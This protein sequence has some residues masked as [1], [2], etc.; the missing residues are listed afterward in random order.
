VGRRAQPHRDGRVSGPR[1]TV[2][3]GGL[4]GISA[5]LQCADAGARVTLVEVRPRLGGAVYSF[6]RDGLLVDNGQHVFMR[7]CSAYRALLE[8]IGATGSTTLQPRLE[9]PVIEPGGRVT[10]IRRGRLPAPLHLAATLARYRPLLPLKRAGAARAAL[11]LGRLDAADPALDLVTFGDWLA[12]HGQGPTEAAALWDLIALA[13]LNVRAAEA[14]LGVA[15]FAFQTALLGDNTA[16]DIGFHER[17]LSEVVGEPAERALRAAG[18]ALRLSWRAEAV[19]AVAGGGGFVVAGERGDPLAADAV[20]MALPPTRAAAVLPAGAIANPERLMAL[21]S[22]PI[23]NVHVIYERPVTDLAFVGGLGTPV[24]YVFD[25]TRAAG[26]EAGQYLAVSVSGADAEM[27]MTPEALRVRY[28]SALAELFPRALATRVE[29][30]LVTREHAATFRATP[31]SAALRPGPR[32]ALAGL[33]LAGAWTATGWPATMEGAVRSGQA[34]AR[35]ALS[36]VGS[37]E[38]VGVAA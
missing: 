10:T 5:A 12:R 2:V 34:A 11:A 25:R 9:V 23:V 31:G 26:V 8:R 24:Q 4:A 29:R 19:R 1:V 17:A 3:G 7:C 22:S 18:V 36:A 37:A 30:F 16:G 33:A 6:E 20:V 27:A 35:E 28:E 38:A 13:I 15:A 14:S 21:G 32:T